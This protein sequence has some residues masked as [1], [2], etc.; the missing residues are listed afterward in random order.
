MSCLSLIMGSQ[1]S[2][3]SFFP[4]DSWNTFCAIITRFSIPGIWN[5][6]FPGIGSIGSNIWRKQHLF[7]SEVERNKVNVVVAKRDSTDANGTLKDK[8]LCIQIYMS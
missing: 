8:I 4:I 3:E 5:L 2:I 6:L 7:F 1:P